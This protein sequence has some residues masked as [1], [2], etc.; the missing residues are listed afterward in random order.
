V[1]P[2]AWA[3][4]ASSP[5]GSA[6]RS[7]RARLEAAESSSRLTRYPLLGLRQG[8]GRGSILPSPRDRR[9]LVSAPVPPFAVQA[10]DGVALETPTGDAAIVLADTRQKD[11]SLTG[12]ELRLRPNQGPALHSHH[13]EDEL[14]FVREGEFR[15]K[16]GDGIPG[17]SPGGMAFG[18]RRTP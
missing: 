16:G 17:A 13:P 6:S 7:R 2:A 14:W 15:F 1:V 4:N 8:T 10:G 11:G 12:H 18:P 3:V 9:W 5:D